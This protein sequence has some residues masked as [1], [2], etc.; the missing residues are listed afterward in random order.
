MKDPRY[1]DLAR[2]LV[3]YS[4]ALKAGEKI[5]IETFDIPPEFTIELIR[6]AAAA[7]GLPFLSTYSVRAQ[8]A[9]YQVASETQM[10]LWRDLD[11]ARMEKMD[12][13]IGVRGSHN[14][15]E[16]S[17]VPRD[18][19]NLYEKLYWHE[20]HSEVRVPKTKW[21]VLRWPHSA[22]AQAAGMSTEAVEDFYFRVCAGVDYAK[23]GRAAAPLVEL[24]D[25]TDRVRLVGPGTELR[26]SKKGIPTKACTGD[27]NI[28]DG[29]CFSCPVKESVE[30][31][32]QFN[33][34]T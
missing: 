29:E 27:R 4:C 10:S 9:L 26:F 30:G 16:T 32:I 12:A 25:R 24:M 34:E 28:P 20:V 11:R 5:L 21:V 14:I 18:K 13:Y 17:D 8:R 7:G 6:A 15:S 19:M 33:C 23:M 3:N 2:L 1:T 22:M 31:E